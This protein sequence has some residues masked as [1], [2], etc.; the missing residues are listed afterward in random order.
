MSKRFGRIKGCRDKTSPRNLIGFPDG[1]KIGST[2][3]CRGETHRY[4]VH[5]HYSPCSGTKQ[6]K[7]KETMSLG[8]G[9]DGCQHYYV[10]ILLAMKQITD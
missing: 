6:D 10:A 8:V 1:S 9:S 4:T 2:V 5:L 3:S 7:T